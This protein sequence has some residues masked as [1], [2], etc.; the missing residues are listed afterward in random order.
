MGC[1]VDLAPQSAN[2][3]Q[4]GGGA[5]YQLTPS[6]EVPPAS[7]QFG[8]QP[9]AVPLMTSA[10]EGA[11]HD[12]DDLRRYSVRPRSFDSG[13]ARPDHH[14]FCAATGADRSRYGSQQGLVRPILIR[15]GQDAADIRTPGAVAG[16]RATVEPL[17]S[18]KPMPL[19]RHSFAGLHSTDHQVCSAS[20]G[21]ATHDVNP[22]RHV[23]RRSIRIA[24]LVKH[25]L[26]LGIAGNG[27][28]T[29]AVSTCRTMP[30]QLSRCGLINPEHH[31]G[32][33]A[34]GDQGGPE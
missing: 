11:D 7:H 12:R 25:E 34:A 31:Q 28:A 21:G 18:I 6:R 10:A 23:P 20:N 14:R 4:A 30:R 9:V 33:A 8:G 29:A 16:G 17:L 15:D 13:R 2:A 32:L 27:G 1:H 22:T 26:H 19:D 24:G 3:A 5:I